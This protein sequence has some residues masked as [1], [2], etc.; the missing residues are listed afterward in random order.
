MTVQR[1][2]A[3]FFLSAGL[4]F[5]QS[6]VA[7]EK[8]EKFRFVHLEFSGTQAAPF[9]AKRAKVFEKYGLDVEIIRIGGSSRVV[10][11]MVAGEIKM[12]HVGA[13][14]V[15]E[16]ALSGADLVIIAS[17]VNV[18][19]FRMMAAPYVKKPADLKGKKIGISRFGG[20]TEQLTRVLLE[21]W[22]IDSSKEVT[23]LQMGGVQETASGLLAKI[24]DA[25]LLSSPQ[26]LRLSDAGF[27]QLADLADLGIPYMSGSIAT[28]KAFI[29]NQ[30]DLVRRFTRGLLEGIKIYKTDREFS[31]RA[32][33]QFTR[34]T[35]ARMLAALWDENGNKVIQKVPLPSA[36]GLQFVMDEV[37]TRKPEAKRLKPAD[38][39]DARFIKELEE[40]GFVKALYG[41]K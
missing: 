9:I 6:V 14:T 4:A 35:D 40:S 36:E 24:V 41:E 28:T 11:A 30:P 19:T 3:I 22:G 8:L 18:P 27:H 1:S 20:A 16:A 7:Q 10:Q 31:I 34:N 23:L 26:H 13:S 5:S 32:L 33:E 25:G 17:T 2:F 15:V 39:I 12:A 29:R 37:A 38:L 21:K